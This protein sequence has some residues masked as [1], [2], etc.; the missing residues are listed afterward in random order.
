MEH[1]A[2]EYRTANIRIRLRPSEYDRLKAFAGG[3]ISGYSRSVVLDHMAGGSSIAGEL[4]A[5]RTEIGKI[6][7]NIN[8]I[9]KHLNEGGSPDITSL[10]DTIADIQKQINRR[11]VKVR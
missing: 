7:N 4:L 8:Q 6:G 5:L 9:A 2:P 11:L 1:K 3:N 10:G